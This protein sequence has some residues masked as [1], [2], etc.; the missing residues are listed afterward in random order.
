MEGI[1]DAI[2]KSIFQPGTAPMLVPFING[3]IALLL[4]TIAGAI[5]AGF[6]SIHLYILGGLSIGLLAS[7]NW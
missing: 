1:A 4:L 6:G 3:T 7:V 5:L 2:I